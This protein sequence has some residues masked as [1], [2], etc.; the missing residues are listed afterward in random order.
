[1][2][3]YHATPRKNRDSIL[4]HGLLPELAD[5][6]RKA[7]WLHTAS[8]REWAILHTMKRHD[9]NLD[10]VDIIAIDLPRSKLTRRWRGLWTCAETIPVTLLHVTNAYNLCRS[11]VEGNGEEGADER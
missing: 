2:R 1:M 10:E 6:K 5:G 11:P 4:E 9:V 8:K 3:L 7:V